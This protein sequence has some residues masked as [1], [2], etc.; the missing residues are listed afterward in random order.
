MFVGP[1]GQV[2]AFEPSLSYILRNTV[3]TVRSDMHLLSN[4][5]YLPVNAAYSMY[6]SHLL[7]KYTEVLHIYM[8]FNRV[9]QIWT[10]EVVSS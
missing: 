3:K 6:F 1:L 8:A 5:L 10:V 9:A 7:L 2:L 4:G